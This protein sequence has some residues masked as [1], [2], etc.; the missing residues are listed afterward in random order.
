MRL[1][2]PLKMLY[3]VTKKRAEPYT[4]MVE[5]LPQMRRETEQLV[6]QAVSGGRFEPRVSEAYINPIDDDDDETPQ[7]ERQTNPINHAYCRRKSLN[8]TLFLRPVLY[9]A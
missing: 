2:T 4:K 9:Q 8:L 1:L 7:R 3:G 5:E 6:R